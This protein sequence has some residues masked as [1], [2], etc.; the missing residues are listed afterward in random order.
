M[1]ISP[2]ADASGT[3]KA[4]EACAGGLSE[5]KERRYLL[6]DTKYGEGF[7]LQ[8]EARQRIL[9]LMHVAMYGLAMQSSIDL[10]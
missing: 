2:C 5:A 4:G 7:N 1:C 6:Y 10:H 9:R 3:C 8:R